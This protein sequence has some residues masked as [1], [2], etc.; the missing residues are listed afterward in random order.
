MKFLKGFFKL[1]LA[2]L[3]IIIVFFPVSLYIHEGTHYIM[4]TMEGIEVTSF[5]V[6][7]S[8]SLE[9]GYL[10]YITIVRESR[11]GYQIQEGIASF[12]GYYFLALTLLFFIVK[13]LKP[14]TVRQLDLMG[15]ERKSHHPTKH[16][17]NP[18]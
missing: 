6:L 10:G 5:H 7:D 11:Y 3:I 18:Y 2:C 15:V 4:Y 13:P 8:D 9:K 1:F 14:F 17:S 16:M 12:F